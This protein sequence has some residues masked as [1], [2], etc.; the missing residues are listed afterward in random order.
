MLSVF[1]RQQPVLDG[2]F[3]NLTVQP[4]LG[5]VRK[6]KSSFMK[7][8]YVRDSLLTCPSTRALIPLF[9]EL[10]HGSER[11]ALCTHGK[12]AWH[13][14]GV[15]VLQHHEA[16]VGKICQESGR[17][18][19]KTRKPL[20]HPPTIRSCYLPTSPPTSWGLARLSS[21]LH[22]TWMEKCN[23]HRYCSSFLCPQVLLSLFGT[24]S[25]C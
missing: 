6:D 2:K 7:T 23:Q 24:G 19:G 1:F 22:S 10:D 4:R 18:R 25:G 8:D 9:E 21:F 13:L 16:M 3:G 12:Y 5:L 11:H 20:P 17:R 15:G 14:K